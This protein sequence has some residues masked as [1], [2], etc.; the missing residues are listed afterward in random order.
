MQSGLPLNI[1][2][3]GSQSSNGLANAT[4]R[5]DVNGNVNYPQA[6]LQFFNTSAFSAPAPGAWGNLT[7]GMVRGPG[8]DNWNISLFKD[9]LLSESRNSRFEL[10]IETFNTFN[11]TQFKDVSS[12]FSSSNFGQVTSTWDPRVFQ[13]GGKL[14]F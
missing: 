12:S 2:L 10:R 11:H 4:N 7:K 13:L 8:R 14:I 9:F 1:T 6:V 5:P 3:G